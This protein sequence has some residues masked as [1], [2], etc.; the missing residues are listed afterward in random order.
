MD[1]GLFKHGS[2]SKLP[3]DVVKLV[4][5]YAERVGKG[6]DEALADLVRKGLRYHEL[7]VMY[8]KD[9]HDKEVWD[10]RYYYLKIEAGYLYYRLRLREV[11]DEMKSLVLTLSGVLGS[12]EACYRRC[13]SSDEKEEV[14]LRR[15]DELRKVVKMYLDKYI[16]GIKQELNERRYVDDEEVLNS[17]EEAV[18]R[19]RK[20]FVNEKK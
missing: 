5:Y 13:L 3:S 10:K 14:E 17:I 12:L 4:E 9:L 7:E 18:K 16:V 2:S 20:V 8:G 11:M 6:F 15:V 19:Y 1:I